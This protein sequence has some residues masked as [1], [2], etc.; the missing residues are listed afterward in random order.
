MPGRVSLAE[1]IDSDIPVRPDEAVAIL[2]E[3]CRQYAA[4]ALRGIPNPT[5]IRLTPEGT[6]LVE[7]PVSRGDLQYAA[8]WKVAQ[9]MTR[10]PVKFGTIGP[11]L[12]AFAVQDKHYKS[13]KD[14]ILAV[15]DALNAER[16]RTIVTEAAE[17][18]AR[19]AL[20]ELASPVKLDALLRTWPGDRAL[21]F[22]DENGGEPAA[23][24]FAAN[25]GP[26]ALVVGPEGRRE[27]E[28]L[29]LAPLPD[30]DER[31]PAVGATTELAGGGLRHRGRS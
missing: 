1:L 25:P 10:K 21:F 29:A 4:G 2:R 27:G 28:R 14:R 23:D 18:C 17:Q 31:R 7:G 11:E 6:V 20:P 5:V 30:R 9:R 8:M 13:I 19:T 26:A 24:A 12:V 22:A 16:A 15:T 3:V